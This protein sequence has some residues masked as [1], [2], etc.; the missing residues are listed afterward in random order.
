MAKSL[1]VSSQS[2]LIHGCNSRLG[3]AMYSTRHTG[4]GR[5]SSPPWCGCISCSALRAARRHAHLCYDMDAACMAAGAAAC[6]HRLP[7]RGCCGPAPHSTEHHKSPVHAPARPGGAATRLVLRLHRSSP[8]EAPM[9]TP[10]LLG[11]RRLLCRPNASTQRLREPAVHGAAAGTATVPARVGS[12][13]CAPV[14][15]E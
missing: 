5:L 8:Q 13:V 10:G 11:R 12:V 1:A 6:I 15:L 7:T 14:L 3:L 4:A 9:H 2:W